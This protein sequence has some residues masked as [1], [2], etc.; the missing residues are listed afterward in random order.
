MKYCCLMFFYCE[1]RL[2]ACFFHLPAHLYL[3]YCFSYHKKPQY[4]F[5]LFRLFF[6]LDVAQLVTRDGS[7][8]LILKTTTG[9]CFG[10]DLSQIGLEH[11]HFVKQHDLHKAMLMAY[12]LVNSIRPNVLQLIVNHF[13]CSERPFTLHQH[14]YLRTFCKPGLYCLRSHD[15]EEINIYLAFGFVS[16]WWMAYRLACSQ[17]VLILTIRCRTGCAQVAVDCHFSILSIHLSTQV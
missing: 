1:K 9:V 3:F 11:F 13:F 16:T 6:R 5:N 8:H 10:G 2:L 17:I 12:L 15:W 14:S 4:R 7:C